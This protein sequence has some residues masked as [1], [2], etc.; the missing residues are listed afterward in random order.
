MPVRAGQGPR[1]ASAILSASRDTLLKMHVF[2]VTQHLHQNAQRHRFWLV[3]LRKLVHFFVAITMR[4]LGYSVL[5]EILDNAKYSLVLFADEGIWNRLDYALSYARSYLARS[6][7]TAEDDPDVAVWGCRTDVACVYDERVAQL[8]KTGELDHLPLYI[9]TD[10]ITPDRRTT[11]RPVARMLALWREDLGLALTPTPF[12]GQLD[13]Y[14]G[15]RVDIPVCHLD[16]AFLVL[17]T[18]LL[19]AEPEDHPDCWERY[20]EEKYACVRR[21]RLL[22]AGLRRFQLLVRERDARRV[23]A[24]AIMR[25][26]LAPDGPIVRI[27][28]R[29]FAEMKGDPR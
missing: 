1:A 6:R 15:V 24:P 14:L 27:A 9:T 26:A 17:Q 13:D 4:F 10:G 23:L 19:Y 22:L 29:S 8:C 12:I 3:S 20:F 18:E 16:K 25:W 7:R 21:E 11:P 5:E 28:K 2:S